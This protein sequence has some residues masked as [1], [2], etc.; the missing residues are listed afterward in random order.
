M[1]RSEILGKHPPECRRPGGANGPARNWP[2]LE[3]NASGGNGLQPVHSSHQSIALKGRGFSRAESPIAEGRRGF[4]PPQKA[5]NNP[6]GLQPRR[7]APK[8]L[9]R[10]L[11]IQNSDAA[12]DGIYLR[13]IIHANEHKGQ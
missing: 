5:A 4:Q 2:N 8:D 9:P 10:K 3:G 12:V 7:N 13:L 11:R 6:R 1:D